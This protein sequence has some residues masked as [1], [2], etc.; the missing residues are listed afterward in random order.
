MLP[1]LYSGMQKVLTP[2]PALVLRVG[3]LILFASHCID[4]TSLGTNSTSGAPEY[5][6]TIVSRLVTA[7]YWQR[8]C[9]LFFPEEDGYTYAS[10]KGKT[11]ADVNAW[12]KGWFLTDTTRLIW[13]NGYVSSDV[14]NEE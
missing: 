11:A 7:E 2:L 9:A 5:M 4:L 8:Q 14:D 1:Y 13:T 10:A 6:P 3:V 12:T